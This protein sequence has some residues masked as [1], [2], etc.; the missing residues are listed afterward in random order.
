MKTRRLRSRTAFRVADDHLERRV[1]FR[2]R[3]G[4]D[5]VHRCTRDVFREAAFAIEDLAA[6]GTTLTELVDHLDA[7]SS[8][9]AAALA[10]M[11]ECGC[12]EMRRRRVYPTSGQLYEDAMTEFMYLAETGASC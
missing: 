4:S 1:T 3:P 12:V 8:Q 9:V 2:G 6:G 5:Y 10:F 7:P 11:K